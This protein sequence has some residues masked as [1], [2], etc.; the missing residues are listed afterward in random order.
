MACRGAEPDR[1]LD[2]C[3]EAQADSASDLEACPD[4]LTCRDSTKTPGLFL[5]SMSCTEDADCPDRS[6]CGDDLFCERDAE[7]E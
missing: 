7:R 5:C 2:F 3:P 1:Y 4:G 6:F